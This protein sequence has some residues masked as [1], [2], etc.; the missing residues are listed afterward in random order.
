M[1][2]KIKKKE[3]RK[4]ATFRYF[5]NEFK[6]NKSKRHKNNKIKKVIIKV[7]LVNVLRKLAISLREIFL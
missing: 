7:L 3:Y 1:T 2:K 6:K 4:T 5:K